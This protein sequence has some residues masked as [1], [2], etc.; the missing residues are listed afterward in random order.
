MNNKPT[1]W[2]EGTGRFGIRCSRILQQ[3][4]DGEDKALLPLVVI[5][6]EEPPKADQRILI[7]SAPVRGRPFII[8]RVDFINLKD[9]T[10]EHLQKMKIKNWDAW[11]SRWDEC[12]PTHLSETNP[13]IMLLWLELGW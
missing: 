5:K 1:P 13:V 6:E 2:N 11:I 12:N 3:V 7:L 9:V 8:S 10:D 4:E